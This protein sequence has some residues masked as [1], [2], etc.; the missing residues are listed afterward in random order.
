MA[1]IDE[2]G[3]YPLPKAVGRRPDD[4]LRMD[5][6]PLPQ[7]H[8]GSEEPILCRR[9]GV[10]EKQEAHRDHRWPGAQELWPWQTDRHMG[11]DDQ[12]SS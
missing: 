1:F 9:I 12:R 7:C 6:D 3:P 5:A 4:E 8:R 11:G 2:G 10:R